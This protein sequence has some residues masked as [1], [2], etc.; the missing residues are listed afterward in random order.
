M[1]NVISNDTVNEYIHRQ[2]K[3]N[4]RRQL[5]HK[6][7]K[8]QTRERE[9]ERAREREKQKLCKLNGVTDSPNIHPIVSSKEFLLSPRLLSFFSRLYHFNLIVDTSRIRMVAN[10]HTV[11]QISPIFDVLSPIKTHLHTVNSIRWHF[12]G[13]AKRAL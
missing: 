9:R 13:Y 10:S 4:S 7:F 8:R 1:N 2:T 3:K 12:D 11:T 6:I 5:S